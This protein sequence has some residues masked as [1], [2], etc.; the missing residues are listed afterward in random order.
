MALSHRLNQVITQHL[1]LL[2]THTLMLQALS[3][4]RMAPRMKSAAT[5]IDENELKKKKKVTLIESDGFHQKNRNFM[6]V[7]TQKFEIHKSQGLFSE[8][9][10]DLLWLVLIRA[11]CLKGEWQ[12]GLNAMTRKWDINPQATQTTTDEGLQKDRWGQCHHL[13]GVKPESKRE[14][15]KGKGNHWPSG[16]R[17]QRTRGPTDSEEAGGVEKDW[18][19]ESHVAKKM[20]R[21]LPEIGKLRKGN[22]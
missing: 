9:V 21:P 14:H 18:E 6:E 2:A 11:V 19:L 22:G 13:W 10:K 12:K 4:W 5:T 1:R 3:S 15:Q 17:L 20:V 8:N 7:N 16:K